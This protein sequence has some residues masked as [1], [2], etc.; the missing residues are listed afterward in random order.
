MREREAATCVA[1]HVRGRRA[2]RRPSRE[3]IAQLR[4][5]TIKLLQPPAPVLWQIGECE[6]PAPASFEEGSAASRAASLE[7]SYDFGAASQS[8]YGTLASSGASGDVGCDASI[9]LSLM[10]NNTNSRGASVVESG[11]GQ[12]EES[13]EKEGLV[14]SFAESAAAFVCAAELAELAVEDATAAAWSSAVLSNAAVADARAAA[15]RQAETSAAAQHQAIACAACAAQVAV[16]VVQQ[17]QHQAAAHRPALSFCLR[18]GARS[19]FSSWSV[20]L[21]LT[22]L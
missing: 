14:F 11:A 9:A 1:R 6:A 15:T 7:D 16:Q 8:V 10:G 13:R 20:G 2:R 18:I 12:E 3:F 22:A 19:L 5:E 4:L 17:A 21:L